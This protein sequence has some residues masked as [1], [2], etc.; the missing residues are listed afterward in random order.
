MKSNTLKEHILLKNEKRS[1]LNHY[2][3]ITRKSNQF[4]DSDNELLGSDNLRQIW[5]NHPLGLSMVQKGDLY[6]LYSVTLYSKGNVHFTTE[7]ANYQ[8]QLNGKSIS[9]VIG[10]TYEDFINNIGGSPEFD[11]WKTWLTDRY[12]F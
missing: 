1:I 6:D 12:L 7:I 2:W 10:C 5:R 3:Q 4:K 9:K 11:D 8:N